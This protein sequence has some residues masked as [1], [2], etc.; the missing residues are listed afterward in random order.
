MIR[1]IDIA[2]GLLLAFVGPGFAQTS[3]S[4]ETMAQPEEQADACVA[5][6]PPRDLAKTSYIRNA[7]R[8]ILRILAVRH[9]QET[10]DC[11]CVISDIPWDEVVAA[12]QEFVTSDDLLRPFDTSEMR[13]LADSMEAE[14]DSAC[15]VE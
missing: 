5:P 13:L 7:Y 14:R 4:F 10:G 1:R 15:E 2:L 11:I 3:G 9:W 12:G 8:A 6:R